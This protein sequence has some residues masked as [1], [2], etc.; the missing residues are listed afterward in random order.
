VEKEKPKVALVYDADHTIL[1]DDHPNLLLR[2]RGIDPNKFWDEINERQRKHKEANP[3]S[4]IDSFYINYIAHLSTNP[5][6]ELHGLSVSELE[7]IGR[8]HLP[9]LFF[10]GIPDFFSDVKLAN[11][12][13][14]IQHSVVSLG[15]DHMLRAALGDYVDRIFAYTF[16]EA[17]EGLIVAGTNTSLEKDSAL[18]KISRGGLYKTKERGFEYPINQMIY[19][20]DGKSDEEAFKQVLRDGGTA[21]CVYN[22]GKQ[23]S[24][25]GARQMAHKLRG[26]RVVPADFRKGK[27]LSKLVN[28]AVRFKT[29]YL[30]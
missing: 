1:M 10:P 29:A 14:D 19:I 21:I 12:G 30:S 23:N 8:D 9:S 15:I 4:N 22:E 5:K 2:A 11:P 17:E 24:E 26:L 27:D 20:G 28:L 3:D 7:Q 25:E 13:V 6:S 18:K 16:T